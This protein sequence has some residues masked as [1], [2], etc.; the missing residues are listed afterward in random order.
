M[1]PP[2]A[3]LLCY[4]L[5]RRLSRIELLSLDPKTPD[6]EVCLLE[7]LCWG[8]VALAWA[9]KGITHLLVVVT[10]KM[11]ELRPELGDPGCGYDTPES[12]AAANF[13]AANYGLRSGLGCLFILVRTSLYMW[14][15]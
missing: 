6:S 3:F 4:E 12:G 11:T 5:G 7:L 1:L 9:F 10:H 14:L 13:L 2:G 15:V 8:L